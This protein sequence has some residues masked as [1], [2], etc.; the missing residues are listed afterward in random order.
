MRKSGV[1]LEERREIVVLEDDLE[2]GVGVL[3]G[4]V[5]LAALEFE[6]G[7]GIGGFEAAEQ[8]DEAAPH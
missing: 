5:D 2:L 1:I 3:H 4:D 8:A 6:C 7:F